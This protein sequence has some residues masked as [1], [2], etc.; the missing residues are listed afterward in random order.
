MKNLAAD[1]ILHPKLSQSLAIL[2]TTVGRDKVTRL[3]QYLAR[4]IAWSLL[5]RGNVEEAARW[6]GLKGGLANGRKV[7]RLFRPAE[8][9]QS[10]MNLA[11][12]PISTFRG[13]GKVAHF[14]QIGRQ[15]GFLKLDKAMA[16]K[17]QRLMYKFWFAGIMCSLISSSA[18]LIR[19]RAD[20]KRFAL[21]AEIA[22]RGEKEAQDPQEVAHQ[23]AERRERGRA[24][25]AQR[26]TILSQLVSDTLDVWIPATGLGYTNV[27]DGVLGAF[28]AI[29]SY[30][31]L[32]TQ[33]RRHAAAGIKRTA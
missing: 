1:I 29:T 33:W 3:I 24:L 31:A 17:Y 7:M 10:A 12:R 8:F 16:A 20:S 23:I 19:L 2:A 5:R 18:S 15:I 6:D 26:Q 4:L 13:P 32:Q 9:L 11:Q 28:G 25:L 21:S 22:K 30:M 27:N 14:A